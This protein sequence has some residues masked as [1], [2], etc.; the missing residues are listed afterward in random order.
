MIHT[1]N[2]PD[3][4]KQLIQAERAWLE[5]HLRLDI[6]ALDRLMAAEY[7]Q[8]NS[9][10]ELITKQEAL[11]SFRAGNRHWEV[12]ESDEYQIEV[13]EDVAVVFG[14]WRA[15]GVNAGQAFDYAARYVSVWVDRDGRWQMVS[16][17]S[18]AVR[19][20]VKSLWRGRFDPGRVQRIPSADDHQGVALEDDTHR[21]KPHKRLALRARSDRA[22][23]VAS[24]GLTQVREGK[25][26]MTEKNHGEQENEQVPVRQRRS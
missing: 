18:S 1:R 12:A 2:D 26:L 4:I 6:S 13:Y 3:R 20:P 9:R 24:W 25:I 17:Q 7:K 8:V 16:D 21:T 10:G 14:R 11:A 5:A 15:K 22:A 19:G 23:E